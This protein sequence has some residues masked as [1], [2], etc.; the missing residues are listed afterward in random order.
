MTEWQPID[1]APKDGTPCLV[2]HSEIMMV[3]YYGWSDAFGEHWTSC[4][5]IE[6]YY[7]FIPT[8]WQ[9]RPEPPR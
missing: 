1:T 8:H 7:S 2:A 3:G 6:D 5:C 9:P 4:S